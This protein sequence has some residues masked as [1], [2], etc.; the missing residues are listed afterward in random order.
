MF[1]KCNRIQTNFKTIH[2]MIKRGMQ[3]DHICGKRITLGSSD[4]SGVPSNYCDFCMM[5]MENIGLET[6][7]VQNVKI[8]RDK[9]HKLCGEL[10]E[11]G[12][13]VNNKDVSNTAIGKE[14]IHKFI[15]TLSQGR[16]FSRVNSS[17]LAI[18]VKCNCKIV[19]C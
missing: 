5:I 3:T 11:L 15:T 6:K 12:S 18:V 1:F 4:A 19:R 8:T 13:E 2:T 9:L 14:P 7:N 17:M 10:D 16:V